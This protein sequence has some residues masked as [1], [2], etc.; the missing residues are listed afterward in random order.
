MDLEL[1]FQNSSEMTLK[2]FTRQ[3]MAA[4]VLAATPF[5][6]FA[7]ES[8]PG[9]DI[10]DLDGKLPPEQLQDWNGGKRVLFWSVPDGLWVEIFRAN[11]VTGLVDDDR[12]FFKRIV[13][14]G[15]QWQWRNVGFVP[16]VAEP[17]VASGSTTD[18]DFAAAL[19]AFEADLGEQPDNSSA[20]QTFLYTT[21][22]GETVRAVRLVTTSICAVG[23]S[24]CPLVVLRDAQPPKP[25][26]FSLEGAWG[27]IEEEGNLLV[28]H[29]EELGVVQID[30]ETGTVNRL[31]AHVP[32]AAEAPPKNPRHVE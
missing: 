22:A 1:D 17:A 20:N 18:A 24:T 3:I 9:K 14:D 16:L 30:V 8:V 7:Q 4:L 11:S 29:Q 23:G 10:L 6:G 31:E 5:S 15:R 32:M 28:E 26:F 19:A 25:V 27:F 12:S 13:A 21:A 2:R